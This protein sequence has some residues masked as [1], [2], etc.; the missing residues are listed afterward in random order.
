MSDVDYWGWVEPEPDIELSEP[1]LLAY[2]SRP[3]LASNQV[4]SVV[5]VLFNTSAGGFSVIGGTSF[6]I[7]EY[8]SGGP[9]HGSGIGNWSYNKNYITW[10]YDP[11]PSVE[12]TYIAIADTS[13]RP[14]SSINP[15][16]DFGADL[17]YF[18]LTANGLYSPTTVRSVPP[19][20]NQ[21]SFLA[22]PGSSS[23][24]RHLYLLSETSPVLDGIITASDLVSGAN[25]ISYYAWSPEGTY[26]FA[27]V[28]DR[29]VIYNRQTTS[30]EL[31]TVQN[32]SPG[33]PQFS[34]DGS[35]LYYT[36][37]GSLYIRRESSGWEV[38]EVVPESGTY[39]CQGTHS[40]S[41]HYPKL[42]PDGNYW[43]NI[44]AATCGGAFD[45][46]YRSFL[47]VFDEDFFL[48][49]NNNVSTFASGYFIGDFTNDSRWFVGGDGNINGSSRVALGPAPSWTQ[50]DQGSTSTGAHQSRSFQAW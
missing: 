12:N 3:Q 2:Q 25:A 22:R 5:I 38:D 39:T 40:F 26:L 27:Q 30:I 31:N 35:L 16:V 37:G 32:Y 43:L 15:S 50:E 19:F 36:L 23:P 49:A 44:F 10:I 28:D 34:D 41:W 4:P 47:R 20:S 11:S 24:L 48:L 42:S 1:G 45:L 33:P 21:I 18:P 13:A 6:P 29:F 17:T 8:N 9:L 14:V 7:T 46:N